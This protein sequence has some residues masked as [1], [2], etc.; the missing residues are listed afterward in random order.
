MANTKTFTVKGISFTTPKG[1]AL[2]CKAD[3]PDRKFNDKG[4]LTTSLVC[5]PNDADVKSFITLLEGVRDQAFKETCES[6]GE[7]KAKAIK[8]RPVFYDETNK[9][10][11]KTG[12]ILFKLKLGSVDEKEATGKQYQI[13]V[14]DAKKNILPKAPRVGNGSTIRCAGFANPYYMAS[15]KEIGVSLMWQKMQ[16]IDLIAADGGDAFGEEEGF[17]GSFTPYGTATMEEA[18][19]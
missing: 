3:M 13:T 4:D 6:L 1:K 11:S 7:V 8:V 15:T 16:I 14:V 17:Q 19:F 18:P 12:N 10:G 9:D 5:D 2:W